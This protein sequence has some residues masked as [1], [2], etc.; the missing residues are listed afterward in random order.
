MAATSL[1]QMPLQHCRVRPLW[2]TAA[3]AVLPGGAALRP[4]P[5]QTSP[6]RELDEAY[7]IWQEVP[8]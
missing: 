7:A 1:C 3:F 4:W 2:P 6:A 8:G 5:F